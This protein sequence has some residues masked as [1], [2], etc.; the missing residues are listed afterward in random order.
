MKR[1]NAL[2]TALTALVTSS[3][4][5]MNASAGTYSNYLYSGA[6]VTGSNH[7]DP[8]QLMHS[9]VQVVCGGDVDV[10]IYGTGIGLPNSFVHNTNRTITIRLYESDYGLDDLA[11]KAVLKFDSP[12]TNNFNTYLSSE[13]YS[14]TLESNY[15]VELYLQY[16]IQHMSGDTSQS[17]PGGLFAY[18]LWVR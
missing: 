16:N 5:A 13:H 12:T 11:Y 8:H 7:D 10:V 4:L 17:V 15:D 1:K 18:Q 3:V 2:I 9:S 14:T 6:G